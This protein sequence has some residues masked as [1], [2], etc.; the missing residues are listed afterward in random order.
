MILSADS[1][2]Q[3]AAIADAVDEALRAAGRSRVSIE[4]YASGK[5]IVVDYGE[6]V[7]HV[8]GKE[9]RAFY[10]IEGLWSDAPRVEPVA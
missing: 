2:R 4:G 8:M 7:T 1:D 9:T 10:D 5:W 3:A 6:V